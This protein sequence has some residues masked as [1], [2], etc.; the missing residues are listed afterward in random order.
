MEQKILRFRCVDQP[1]CLKTFLLPTKI[2]WT[3]KSNV[4]KFSLMHV[5]ILKIYIR[6]L[7]PHVFK[8]SAIPTVSV[9]NILVTKWIS[10]MNAL[11]NIRNK[12]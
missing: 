4:K 12:F 1:F 11:M 2:I 7:D 3:K 10:K 5:F 8:F 9:E 6:K